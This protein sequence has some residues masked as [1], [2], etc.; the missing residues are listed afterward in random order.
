MAEEVRDMSLEEKPAA[1]EKLGRLGLF[2]ASSETETYQKRKRATKTFRWRIP[3]SEIRQGG[4]VT[5]RNPYGHTQV[6]ETQMASIL[7]GEITWVCP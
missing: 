4:G 1:G 2:Q 6:I 5:I 7:R 3:F